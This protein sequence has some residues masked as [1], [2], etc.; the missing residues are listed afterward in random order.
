MNQFPVILQTFHAKLGTP[1]AS[2]SVHKS[3]L[4]LPQCYTLNMPC[5]TGGT[6]WLQKLHTSQSDSFPRLPQG[7]TANVLCENRLQKLGHPMASEAVYK[8]FSR[9]LPCFT[10]IGLATAVLML[11]LAT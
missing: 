9:L 5:E 11:L 7:F 3:F 10:S 1:I 8:S 4:R 2:E 6:L